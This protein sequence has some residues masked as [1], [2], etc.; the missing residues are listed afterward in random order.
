MN[1]KL[2]R[3]VDRW[4]AGDPDP[5][6]R[7]ELEGLVAAGDEE[8][9]AARFA[10]RLA[11]GT[12]GLRGAIGAGPG[13][14]NTAVIRQ[15]TAGLADWL[16]S[17]VP[18]ARERGVVVGFDARLRSAEFARDV[19]GVLLA[20][21][22]VVH[23]WSQPTPTPTTPW[24]LLERD[25][26]AGVQ[27]TASHNPPSDNGYKVFWDHGA[28]IVP[29]H[30]KG[31]AAAIDEVAQQPACDIPV[32][33]PEKAERGRWRP[34]GQMAL[35]DY[36]RCVV[37][38]TP[39][40]PIGPR[41]LRIV[42][43]ALH[44][45]G[46]EVALTV[47]NSAGFD[48]VYVVEEQGEPDGTFPTV[49]YPNPEDHATLELAIAKAH[50]VA[51]DLVLA[52]DPDADRLAVLVAKAGGYRVL[53]GNEVGVL[54]GDFCLR[55]C[56]EDSPL[57]AATIV[58][59][60][61]L[62]R[63]AEAR[64]ARF[65]Q[66]LTGF[67]WIMDAARRAEAEPNGP[68]FVYGYEEAI[69]YTVG[70]LVPDKDGISAALAVCC[71]AQKLANTG[72][73]LLDGLDD[74]YEHFGSWHTT[75]LLHRFS[76]AD[77]AREMTDGMRAVRAAPPQQVADL[78]L[79]RIDD[80]LEGVRV[81]GADRTALDGP[82]ANLLCLSYEPSDGRG[83]L[84]ILLRPSGTEPKLKVYLEWHD[85]GGVAVGKPRLEELVAAWEQ[86]DPTAS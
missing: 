58:S 66:T 37:D 83:D 57:V 84:R 34:A 12:A 35:N 42:Y 64:G 54:L 39:H 60:R 2:V 26:A 80:Y 6:D 19:A 7:E 41:S 30:D 8:D 70:R 17:Q 4:L 45:V 14:M 20:R 63:V 23:T 11:F 21:G 82:R 49:S 32:L 25:A 53:T 72:H 28:Q 43:T 62:G 47:L 68:R 76:G 61:L 13:C 18:N 31:I 36:C 78:P 59:S 33:P 52:N 24:L 67:K 27:V 81:E 73:T 65:A 1:D 15:T 50:E 74:L 9:V 55:H 3:Q 10:G 51:A 75:Q 16:A 79:V 29:P 85:P 22:F 44:G 46:Q 48:G 40:Q 71:L 5:R 56:E 77:A 86:V 69:G 38:A